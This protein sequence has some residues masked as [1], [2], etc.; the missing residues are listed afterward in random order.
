MTAT[1][2]PRCPDHR[3]RRSYTP[4]CPSCRQY[5][6]ERYRQRSRLSA[7]GTW[8]G[9][10]DAGPAREHI[11]L[12]Y[13]AGMTYRRISTSAGVDQETIRDLHL[14]IRTRVLPVTRDRI[15]AAAYVPEFYV[16]STGAARRLQALARAQYGIPHL[17]PLLPGS[18]HNSLYKWRA[19]CSPIIRLTSHQAVARLYTRLW[20][21]EGP[22]PAVAARAADRGWHPFEAWTDQTIDNPRATPYGDPE[23]IEFVDW[24]KINRARLEPR[25]PM[26]VPFT[27]LTPAEQDALYRRHIDAG[28]STRGFRDRYRPVPIADLRRLVGTLGGNL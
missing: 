10:V 2:L 13:D 25:H 22:A 5:T 12:L 24:E 18:A 14:S 1:T 16:D 19:H 21:T 3:G 8:V 7:Y 17:L 9:Y 15:L 23:A 28:G 27:Q 11:A 4:G 20:D 26:R 6:R